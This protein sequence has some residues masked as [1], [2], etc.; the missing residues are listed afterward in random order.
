MKHPTLIDVPKDSPSKRE[1][2]EAFKKLH[3]IW[4]H[5][6][7]YEPKDEP[8]SALA[9]NQSAVALN[10]YGVK[11]ADSPL[12][13]IAGYC[14]LLDEWNLLVTGETEREAIRTLCEKNGIV[15]DL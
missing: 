15:F 3:G 9:L 5:N 1:R 10:G 6:A 4:T 7:G 12:D 14:R 8:W 11:P 13:I 2:L